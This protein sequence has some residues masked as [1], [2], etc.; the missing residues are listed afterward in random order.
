[1]M[2]ASKE[3]HIRKIELSFGKSVG[4]FYRNSLLSCI[5]NTQQT[6][7]TISYFNQMVLGDVFALPSC[8][9]KVPHAVLMDS[10]KKSLERKKRKVRSDKLVSINKVS[11]RFLHI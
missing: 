3:K 11:L 4:G 7:F 10:S 1:M 8:L 5:A 2:K 6:F 9:L